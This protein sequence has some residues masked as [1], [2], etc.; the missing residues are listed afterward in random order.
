MK[1]AWLVLL[2]AAR[3]YGQGPGGYGL[4]GQPGINSVITLP[5]AF[6]PAIRSYAVGTGITDLYTAPA[7]TRV[8][9]GAGG[10]Y[11]NTSGTIVWSFLL[12]SG[13]N[14]YRLVTNVSTALQQSS[15]VQTLNIILDAGESLAVTADVAGLNVT[16]VGVR[17]SAVAGAPRSVK[18]LGPAS[19]NTTMYTVPALTST[20]ILSNIF[21]IPVSTAAIFNWVSDSGGTRN[22]QVCVAASGGATTCAANSANQVV[23]FATT[24][25]T[26]TSL[27][28]MAVTL[29]AADFIVMNVDTGAATQIGWI[30]I[31]ELLQ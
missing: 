19:G 21:S 31:V 27:N 5:D 26:R 20:L 3:L 11:N 30:N 10:A 4:P 18:V 13:G 7:G 25:S 16:A 23:A 28:Q 1:R 24:A 17:Y 9:I 14:Y 29:A 22:I 12:K 6:Y 2:L 8:L 15:A